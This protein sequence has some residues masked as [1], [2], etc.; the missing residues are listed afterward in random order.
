MLSAEA[1]GFFRASKDRLSRGYRLVAKRKGNVAVLI[2][3]YLTHVEE[4]IYVYIYICVCV[5]R[6]LAEKDLNTET[7]SDRVKGER[8]RDR[9]RER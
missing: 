8:A 2:S 6:L 3:Q 7:D 5:Y 9:Q 4:Y 1:S